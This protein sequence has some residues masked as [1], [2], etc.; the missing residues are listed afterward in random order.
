MAGAEPRGRNGLLANRSGFLEAEISLPAVNQM[1]DDHVIK[2]LDLENPGSFAE[3]PSQAEIRF[4]RARVSGY[5]AYGISG[6]IPH[7][8][9]CRM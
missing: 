4:A 5:A 2:H 9:L 7:P 1:S 8:V 3:P 6:V